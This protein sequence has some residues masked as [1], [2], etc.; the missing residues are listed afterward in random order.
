MSTERAEKVFQVF[1]FFQKILFLFSFLLVQASCSVYQ[2]NSRKQFEARASELNLSNSSG[3]QPFLLLNS[4]CFGL[5]PEDFEKLLNSPSHEEIFYSESDG[6]FYSCST[7]V[8]NST[9][10]L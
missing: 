9:S 5:T 4:D 10:A 1:R 7:S 3:V 8:R 6:V 2:S